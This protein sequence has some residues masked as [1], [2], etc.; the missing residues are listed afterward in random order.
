MTREELKESKIWCN[1]NLEDKYG[2]ITKVPVDFDGN[3]VG[4]D[5]KYYEKW[6]D[7]ATAKVQVDDETA[8]GVGLIL[9]K[10]TPDNTSTE[11]ALA[12]IDIDHKKIDDFMAQDILGIMDTY[13][14][15]SPSGN[16]LHLLFLVDTTKLPENYKDTYYMKNPHNGVECYIAGFTNRFL[17]FTENVVVDKDI[18][19]RTDNLIQFLNTYMCRNNSVSEESDVTV[20]NDNIINSVPKNNQVIIDTIL[21]TKQSDK[22]YKLFFQGDTS[23]YDGDDSSADMALAEMLA[24]YVGPDFERIDNL[25]KQSS[26]YR[27]KWERPD[28][29]ENTI[30]KAIAYCNGNFFNWNNEE[31]QDSNSNYVGTIYTLTA[32]EIQSLNVEP[33]TPIV[34]NMLYPGFSLLAG[35]PKVGKSWACLDLSLSICRGEPFITFNTNKSDVLYLALEDSVHRLKDRI[36]KILGEGQTAPEGFHIAT[37]CHAI[38]E[39]LLNELQNKLI[40]NPD[41]KLIIIDTLQKVRGT[42]IKG[43]TWYASDYK[44]IAKLKKFADINKVC[45]LAIHHLRKQKDS[46]PFNQISGSTGITGAADTMITLTKME[47]SNGEV[48]MSITGRDVDYTEKILK[49]NKNTFKWEVASNATDF[50]SYK[51]QLSYN[52]NPII[53]TIKALVHEHP[54][55]FFITATE[56]LK[57]IHDLTGVMPRQNKPQTLSR[58][59]NENLQFQLWDFDKIYYEAGNSNGGS[60]GR[61]MYFCNNE[62][63]FKLENELNQDTNE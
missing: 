60:S 30:N 39:G 61:K 16:G 5:T 53:T 17:T 28:Y 55:G 2:K 32:K 7:Y 46:D 42:A 12:G 63:K 29:K 49:F 36:G 14:E 57:A 62:H 34:T 31:V 56:L 15:I 41:I 6:C 18:N 44:E 23:D 58:E 4:T 24:F 26:L 47:N 3:P 43:E 8:S 45:I 35:S 50:E 21:G 22:F 37:S 52:K 1:W 51:E 11:L 40:E 59:I 20:S 27:V 38:D 25:M 9:N 33:P 54:E 10:I 19:E 13:A 48:M